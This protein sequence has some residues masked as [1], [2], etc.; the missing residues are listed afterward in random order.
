VPIS[1]RLNTLDVHSNR[2]LCLL[3]TEYM[4]WSDAIIVP[5]PPSSGAKSHKAKHIEPGGRLDVASLVVKVV[6]VF[7][8]S[9]SA[10]P[11]L[12]LPPSLRIVSLNFGRL[13][14]ILHPPRGQ[15]PHQVCSSSA[16]VCSKLEMG[17]LSGD[18]VLVV[19]RTFLSRLPARSGSFRAFLSIVVHY[20][21]VL[22]PV[23]TLL[24]S[25]CFNA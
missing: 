10:L 14:I 17:T 9:Y 20:L 25:H 8:G 11:W 16:A 12:S 1:W 18:V 21:L 4:Q 2:F 24:V 7:S 13:P 6:A 22:L 19:F 23:T 15:S 5:S 3:D